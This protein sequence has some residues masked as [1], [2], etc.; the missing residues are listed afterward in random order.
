MA[1][2]GK[3]ATSQKEETDVL[4]CPLALHFHMHPQPAAAPKMSF[5]A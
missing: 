3:T 1:G 4:N 5:I 2:G